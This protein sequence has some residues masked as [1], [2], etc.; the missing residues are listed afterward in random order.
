MTEPIRKN[1]FKNIKIDWI[2]FLKYVA[3]TD[4]RKEN[5]FPE[6]VIRCCYRPDVASRYW[7]TLEWEDY[8]GSKQSVSAQK[9]ELLFERATELQTDLDYQKELKSFPFKSGDME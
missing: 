5:V 1:E 6:V 4:H 8:D 9:F 3:Q 2:G 7:W